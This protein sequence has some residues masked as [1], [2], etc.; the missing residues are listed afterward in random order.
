MKP[1]QYQTPY[2]QSVIDSLNILIQN[3]SLQSICM[4][5]ILRCTNATSRVGISHTLQLL[6]QWFIHLAPS[7]C[8]LLPV[9]LPYKL[10]SQAFLLLLRSEHSQ[11]MLKTLCFIVI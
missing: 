8:S 5:V 6:Q 7:P 11:I 9:H 2:L 10:M 3:K 1:Q 4:E